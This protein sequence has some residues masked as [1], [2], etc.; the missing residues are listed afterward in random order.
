MTQNNTRQ[1]PARHPLWSI[2]APQRL[3]HRACIMRAREALMKHSRP[4]LIITSRSL[5]ATSWFLS[6]RRAP[7]YK[8]LSHV[9]RLN[10]TCEQVAFAALTVAALTAI[11]LAFT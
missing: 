11:L 10:G 7:L 3:R 1:R 2:C 4:G 9:L 5:G 8:P 6:T